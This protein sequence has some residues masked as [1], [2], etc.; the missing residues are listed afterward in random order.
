MQRRRQLVLVSTA[1]GLALLG[2]G[3]WVALHPTRPANG[4]TPPAPDTQRVVAAVPTDTPVTRRAT[5]P[6]RHRS[7]APPPAVARAKLSLS[8]QPPGTFFLDDTPIRSTP[9]LNLEIVPGRHR[10]QVKR[11]GFASFDTVF[12]AKPGEAIKW[13]RIALKPIG[14]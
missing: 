4:A 12:T 5:P 1:L 11:D 2:G 13:T 3:A 8:T 6:P 9:I 14:G 10:A 7:S